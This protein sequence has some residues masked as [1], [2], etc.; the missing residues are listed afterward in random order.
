MRLRSLLARVDGLRGFLLGVLV[1]LYASAQWVGLV[2]SASHALHD[3]A[4]PHPIA[5]AACIAAVESA[6]GPTTAVPE[7]AIRISYSLPVEPMPTAR[8]GEVLLLRY[9][10]R[11]PPALLG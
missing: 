10:S 6:A 1:I 2:H 11:A 7:I 5:C 3:R 9:L 4:A 8:S